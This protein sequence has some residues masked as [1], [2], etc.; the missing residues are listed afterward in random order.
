M[1]M[2]Q[3]HKLFFLLYFTVSLLFFLLY[4][5]NIHNMYNYIY[6]INQYKF[7]NTDM[8]II[9]INRHDL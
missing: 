6:I 3:V 9:Y 1:F 7:S 8:G 4:I 5:I 2:K